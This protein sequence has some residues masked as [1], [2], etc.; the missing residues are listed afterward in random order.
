MVARRRKGIGEKRARFL[1]TCFILGCLIL[2]GLWFYKTAKNSVFDGKHQLNIAFDSNHFFLISYKPDNQTLTILQV[3]AD[4]YVMVPYSF[5]NYKIQAVWELSKLSKKNRKF[6]TPDLLLK[7]TLRDNFYFFPEAW[8]KI[9]SFLPNDFKLDK[10]KTKEILKQNTGFLGL[11][12]LF[13]SIKTQRVKTNLTFIDFLRLYFS[14]SNLYEERIFV[15]NLESLDVLKKTTLSDGT[16][17]KYL[18]REKLLPIITKLFS[19]QEVKNE[20]LTISIIN[21]SQK[22]GEGKKV[23]NIILALGGRVIEIKTAEKTSPFSL[24]Q[25]GDMNFARSYTFEKIKT[26]FNCN[27]EKRLLEER[28]DI[29][30]VIGE[31]Y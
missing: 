2:F 31:D 15:Y 13:K 27:F 7:K 23:G 17:L 24:C 10:K 29:N 1:I 21:A 6:L 11:I 14:L 3:P 19:N 4:L 28:G 26:I 20:N 22:T 30:L 16:K 9:N 8:V 18:E 25:V 12:S 5:G